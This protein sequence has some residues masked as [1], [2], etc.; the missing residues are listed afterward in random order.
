MQNIS[1]TKL[2]P[3]YVDPTSKN[4]DYWGKVEYSM[5]VSERGVQIFYAPMLRFHI[6][7][8]GTKAIVLGAGPQVSWTK[9]SW[10]G[11]TQSLSNVSDYVFYDKYS[12]SSDRNYGLKKDELWFTAE[13]AFLWNFDWGSDI[14]IYARYQDGF[15]IGFE[16]RIG[17]EY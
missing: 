6:P 3:A 17:R 4:T 9:F 7:I 16:Y 10:K 8:K 5:Y 12:S 11:R 13:V 2:P 15:Y 1:H 14:D